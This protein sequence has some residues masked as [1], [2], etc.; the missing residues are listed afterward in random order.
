MSR[1]LKL[2]GLSG[3]SALTLLRWSKTD[4]RVCLVW[5]VSEN[6]ENYTL[7]G[8]VIA[9]VGIFEVMITHTYELVERP[10]AFTQDWSG[11]LRL[12]R[13]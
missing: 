9:L 12:R 3:C 11:N 13:L 8:G 2:L 7:K 1:N 4:L 10:D 5:V 6:R